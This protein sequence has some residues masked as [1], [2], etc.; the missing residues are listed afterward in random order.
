MVIVDNTSIKAAA[1]SL[2]QTP[3]SFAQ[4]MCITYEECVWMSSS[5]TFVNLVCVMASI[6]L[7]DSIYH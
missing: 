1:G 6:L 4:T 2:V 7:I 3:A 5:G